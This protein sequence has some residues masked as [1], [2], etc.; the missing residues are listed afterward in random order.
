VQ[1]R[2]QCTVYLNGT[3]IKYYQN[4]VITMSTG[5]TGI[6]HLKNLNYYCYFVTDRRTQRSSEDA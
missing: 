2:V 4:A 6:Y 1:T 3:K 5:W